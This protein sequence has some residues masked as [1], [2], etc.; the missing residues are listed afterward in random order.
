MNTC[1]T[2]SLRS[3]VPFR[4]SKPD[5]IKSPYTG[6]TREEWIRCG[7]YI[8]EGISIY[9]DDIKLPCFYPNSRKELP[10]WRQ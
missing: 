9:V 4:I 3:E 5:Y 10:G 7:I 2:D 8:L 1:R 6:M